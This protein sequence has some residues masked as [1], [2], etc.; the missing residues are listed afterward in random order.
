MYVG[1]T[2]A[3]SESALKYHERTMHMQTL[4]LNPQA[5]EAGEISKD[6]F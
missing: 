6:K 4:A 5:L 3:F 1:E 2:K